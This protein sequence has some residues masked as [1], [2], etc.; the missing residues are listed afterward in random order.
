MIQGAIRSRSAA[1]ACMAILVVAVGSLGFGSCR[2]QKTVGTATCIACHNGV[3]APDKTEFLDSAHRNIQCELCHGPGFDHV[4]NA[5]RMGLFIDNPGDLPFADSYQ[6]CQTCHEENVEGYLLTLHAAE[7]AA[8]CHTC[9]DVHTDNGL[10]FNE[11]T[12][13]LFD[14][15]GYESLCGTCHEVQVDD[16]LLSHHSLEKVA[17]CRNCH[18][19]HA[20]EALSQSAVDNTICLQCHASPVLGFVDEETID[21][22]TGGFHPVDPTGS[23][24]SRCI[25][26]HMPPLQ[27]AGQPRVPHDHTNFTVPPLASNE[28]ADMGILPVPPN[29]CAGVMGCHDPDSPGTGSP[30][31]VNNLALNETLQPLYESIGAGPFDDEPVTDTERAEELYAIITGA[32]PYEGWAQ[33]PEAQGTIESSPP[34]GPLSQVFINDPVESSIANFMGQLEEGSIIVKK[35]FDEDMN[36]AGDAITVMWKLA[37]FDPDNNDWFWAKYAFDGEIAAAGRII[38]CIGCHGGLAGDNDFVFLHEFSP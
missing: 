33:F 38:G 2:T 20:P 29:S 28:A 36:E 27:Q 30:R 11:P 32:D 21:R 37:D 24:A 7:E 22:H 18:D 17:G 14:T 9:H 25:G 31:D 34:H 15:T 35:S 8:S 26:C 3:S 5:G 19:L 6:L 13:G 4:R 16:F 12:G 23:G 10:V 1:A